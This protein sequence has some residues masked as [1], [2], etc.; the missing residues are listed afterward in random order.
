VRAAGAS[1]ASWAEVGC[2]LGV[3]KQSAANRFTQP[4]ARTEDNEG[5]RAK[6]EGRLGPFSPLLIA[7]FG[8]GF[9]ADSRGVT[10]V[11]AG[12]RRGLR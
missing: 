3:S 12:E 9:S 6:G 7:R 1:S 5:S 4:E 10:P 11:E 2:R 8:V